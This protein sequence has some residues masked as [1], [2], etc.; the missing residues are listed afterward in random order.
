MSLPYSHLVVVLHPAQIAD[1]E[2]VCAFKS[3][4]PGIKI[5]ASVAL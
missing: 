2:L 4:Y 3:N 1:W 5:V